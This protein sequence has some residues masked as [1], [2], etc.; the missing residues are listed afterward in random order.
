MV[1]GHG[2]FKK[3]A[4]PFLAFPVSY[5]C[6]GTSAHREKKTIVS[7][8]VTDLPM[9]LDGHSGAVCFQ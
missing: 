9:E 7:S 5:Q 3:A 6:A 4:Y 1:S 2:V 8:V